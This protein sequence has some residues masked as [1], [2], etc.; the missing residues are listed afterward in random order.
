MIG[1]RIFE[2]DRERSRAHTEVLVRTSHEL[3]GSDRR[4]PPERLLD[5]VRG[6]WDVFMSGAGDD[7]G[8]VGLG[9]HVAGVYFPGVHSVPDIVQQRLEGGRDL[10]LAVTST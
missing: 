2:R 1:E 6:Q 8:L 10:V 7:L 9:H 3:V 4:L 5:V